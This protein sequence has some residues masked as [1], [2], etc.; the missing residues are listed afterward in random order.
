M[1]AYELI[2]ACQIGGGPEYQLRVPE[3]HGFMITRQDPDHRR[4]V[5]FVDNLDQ[6]QTFIQSLASTENEVMAVHAI[7]ARK[8]NP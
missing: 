7:D 5:A 2:E 8:D 1:K 4:T 3:S 6:W